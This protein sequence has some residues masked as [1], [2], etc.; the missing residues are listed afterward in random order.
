M[1]LTVL[2]LMF[3]SILF[4]GA[5]SYFITMR[6]EQ[7]RHYPIYETFEDT[8]EVRTVSSLFL[9]ESVIARALLIS[10]LI[11]FPLALIMVLYYSHRIAGPLYHIEKH[12][13]LMIEGECSRPLRLRKGDE[14]KEIAEKIN[15]LQDTL[16]ER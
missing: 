6:I 11:T 15:R 1:I 2:L 3:T 5:F 12:L 7:E 16:K 13:G 9:A 14:F 8:D 10:V 4:A